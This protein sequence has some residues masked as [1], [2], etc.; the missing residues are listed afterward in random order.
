MTAIFEEFLSPSTMIE[1]EQEL[2]ALGDQAVPV[3]ESLL[4]GDAKNRFGVPYRTLG[5]PLRCT[6]EV[7]RRLG[8]VAKPLERYLRDELK[9]GDPVA[10]MAL[11]SLGK[12]EEAS[13]VELAAVLHDENWDLSLESALA[14]V[15]CGAADHPAVLRAMNESQKARDSMTRA[16]KHHDKRPSFDEGPEGKV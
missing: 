11:G 1:A 9:S 6:L 4:T 13:V 3:L 7:A 8:P 15:R 2:L 14:L 16:T 12:L 5:L 10:A